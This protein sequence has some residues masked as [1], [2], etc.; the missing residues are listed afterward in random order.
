MPA[1]L[2]LSLEESA[3][4]TVARLAGADVAKA[5]AA[6]DTAAVRADDFAD[7]Q[8][9]AVWSALEASVRDGRP[10]D[11][12]DVQARVPR[13]SRERLVRL[14]VEDHLGVTYFARSPVERLRQVRDAGDRRRMGAALASV[15]QLVADQSCPLPEAVAEAQRALEVVHQQGA[16]TRTLDVDVMQLVDH[17]EEVAA[18]RRAPVLETGLE[19]LDAAIGGLQATLTVIGALPGVGKSGLL[20][21]IVRNLAARKVVSGVL[22][23]EDEGQWLVR[24]LVAQAAAVPVFVLANRPLGHHQRERVGQAIEAAYDAMTHVLVDDRPALSTAEVVSSARGMLVRGAKAL[25]LDHLGEVRL[26]RTDRHDLDVAEVL[27]QLRA[28][29]KSYRVPVIVLCHLRRREGLGPKDEP[30]LTDFA[31]SAAVERMSRVSLALSRPH[32]NV[33]RVFILKQTQGV[34]GISV[35]LAFDGPSGLVTNTPAPATRANAAALYD[36]ESAPVSAPAS[37][38]AEQVDLGLPGGSAVPP[39]GDPRW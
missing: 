7:H 25:F 38:S 3:V 16:G 21:A 4:A 10:P 14:L 36:E 39:R 27:Q 23:L 13:V 26:Q 18:G 32:D 2:S 17:L 9:R 12:F 33:L 28:L 37:S 24:R 34:A 31:F 22:S 19:A 11:L 29:A 6:I 30:R 1:A 35:D 20:A 8:V 5:L 15:L